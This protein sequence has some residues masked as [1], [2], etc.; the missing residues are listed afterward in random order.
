MQV[1]PH[2]S[3]SITYPPIFRKLT[4]DFDDWE[5][6]ATSL[7]EELYPRLFQTFTSE[8]FSILFPT[9]R[10]VFEMKSTTQRV[11]QRKNKCYWKSQF[12]VRITKKNNLSKNITSIHQIIH[13]N[14]CS[15]NVQIKNISSRLTEPLSIFYQGTETSV[16]FVGSTTNRFPILGFRQKTNWVRFQRFFC[17][18]V[19]HP[20][21]YRR[22]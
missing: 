16:P 2:T 6:R 13:E 4:F 20:L 18:I 8:V 5:L 22:G 14:F 10:K 15:K 3:R 11:K 19:G 9:K 21:F 7:S 12:T 1:Q 17:S